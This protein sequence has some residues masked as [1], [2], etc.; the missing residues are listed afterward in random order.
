M[1]AITT[2]DCK[3]VLELVPESVYE[4]CDFLLFQIA[5][6]NAKTENEKYRLYGYLYACVCSGK[7][8]MDSLERIKLILSG[9]RWA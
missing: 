3:K 7:M 2:E 8:D 9:T 6:N 1:K 4:Y 5:K